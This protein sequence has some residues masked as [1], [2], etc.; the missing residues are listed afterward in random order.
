MNATMAELKL[1]LD[2]PTEAKAEPSQP[3]DPIALRE[4]IKRLDNMVVNNTVKVSLSHVIT[5]CLM[6]LT[7][8]WC[9]SQ[10]LFA[11]G[12]NAPRSCD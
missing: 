1:D 11:S 5:S 10:K 3:S 12:G 2:Q 9:I 6:S 4:A 8:A 7:G